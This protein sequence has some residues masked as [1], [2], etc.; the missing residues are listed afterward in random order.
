MDT[1]SESKRGCSTS[2][3]HVPLNSEIV[4]VPFVSVVALATVPA[5][6]SAAVKAIRAPLSGVRVSES[7]KVPRTLTRFDVGCILLT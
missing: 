2:I 4:N 1:R 3:S 6:E 5:T 7:K